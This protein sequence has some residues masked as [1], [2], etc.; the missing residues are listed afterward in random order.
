MEWRPPPVEAL[1]PSQAR[2]EAE[3]RPSPLARPTPSSIGFCDLLIGLVIEIAKVF[4]NVGVG[5]GIP[6]LIVDAVEDA[7]IIVKAILE[8]VIQVVAAGFGQQLLGMG[9]GD[10]RHF[11]RVDDGRFQAAGCPF[12]ADLAR[13][14]QLIGQS[15]EIAEQKRVEHAL[16][17]R[18]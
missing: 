5:L 8:H 10:G 18:L 15:I 1:L 17:R 16:K 12:E 4:I 13:A 2:H 9:R 3:Q 7:R 6:F 11:V 14:V